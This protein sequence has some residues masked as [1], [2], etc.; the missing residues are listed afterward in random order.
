MLEA[1]V[2]TLLTKVLTSDIYSKRPRRNVIER[3]RQAPER[4]DAKELKAF[5]D[6]MLYMPFPD[7]PSRLMLWRAQIHKQ[8]QQGATTDKSKSNGSSGQPHQHRELPD[9]FDL[10][11]L[12]HISEGFSAGAICATVKKTLT[13]RRVERLDKRAH[14][15]SEF[16]NGF[17]S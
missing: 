11:T 1:R 7:Y 12:A 10:S 13:L 16:L 14:S 5:F 2:R 4:A 15:E 8:L 6:K 3:T 9:D 17:R